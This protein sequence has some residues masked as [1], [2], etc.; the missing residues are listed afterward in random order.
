MTSLEG[1]LR[2]S[3][4]LS[5]CDSVHFFLYGG[6][7]SQLISHKI[8]F[9]KQWDSSESPQLKSNEIYAGAA[10]RLHMNGNYRTCRPHTHINTHTRWHTQHDGNFYLTLAAIYNAAPYAL[11]VCEK[12]FLCV[13]CWPTSGAQDA[14]RFHFGFGT[15][16]RLWLR[17]FYEHFG[18]PLSWLLVKTALMASWSPTAATTTSLHLWPRPC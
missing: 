9:G 2:C 3:V 13:Y 15:V 18:P 12:E 5:P 16:P 1:H 8:L 11:C 17:T 14:E 6:I 7:E 4:R 10:M